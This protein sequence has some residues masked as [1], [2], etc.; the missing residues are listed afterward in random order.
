MFLRLQSI[1]WMRILVK[2][3]HLQTL[4]CIGYPGNR[5]LYLPQQSTEA[6]REQN[7][8]QFRILV[9]AYFSAL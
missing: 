9:D 7:L 5:A 3:K 8:E 6:N 2:L 1:E 4:K